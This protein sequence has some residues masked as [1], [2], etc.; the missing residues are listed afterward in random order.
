MSLL[1]ATSGREETQA[2]V[3][4]GNV[5]VALRVE[6][7]GNVDLGELPL[8]ACVHRSDFRFESLSMQPGQC[9]AA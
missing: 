9:Q 3:Q 8:G 1:G 5:F 4:L 6:R 7:G 2:C